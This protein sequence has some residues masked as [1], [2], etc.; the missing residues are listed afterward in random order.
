[1]KRIR[2]LF[3]QVLH[4]EES[5]HRTALAFAIGVFIA[6]SPTYGLHLLSAVFA[7]WA[8]RLNVIALM[9]GTL[10]N[11]PWTL[12][13]ILAATFWAGFQVMAIPN[14]PPLMWQDLGIE[15]FYMHIRP[16]ALPFFI[17]GLLLGSIG[18]AIAYPLAYYVVSQYRSRKPAVGAPDGQLPGESS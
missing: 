6:F 17:G 7:S 2:S 15:S 3:K 8:F 12:V 10:I 5:P 9:A 1:M 11:N 16:Y 13:P 14:S 4:L 18:A